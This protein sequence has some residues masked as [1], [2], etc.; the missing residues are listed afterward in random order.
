MTNEPAEAYI[1]DENSALDLFTPGRPCLIRFAENTFL[2]QISEVTDETIRVTFYAY[3][4]PVP[5]ML[6]DLEF[7]QPEGIAHFVAKVLEGPKRER[8]GILLERPFSA[9]II[10]HRATY[11][12]ATDIDTSFAQVDG[13]QAER[14]QVR[15]LST[16]GA[17]VESRVRLPHGAH[18][19]LN[20]NFEGTAHAIEAEVC[21]VDTFVRSDGATFY[22]YGTRFT[23]YSPGAG[24]AVTNYVWNRL[25]SLY[26]TI[27]SDES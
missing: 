16:T 3:D 5:G 12:A 8:D 9:Q 15:N 27:E 24:G 26:P 14:C 21:H 19:I 18:I 20:L 7:H 4:F 6:V 23:N 25:K 1:L 11:R 2:V 17:S 22:R 10:Q 13:R